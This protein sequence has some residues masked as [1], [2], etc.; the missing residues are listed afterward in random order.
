MVGI[1]TYLALISLNIRIVVHRPYS[2]SNTLVNASGAS[3]DGAPVHGEGITAALRP[4]EESTVTALPLAW[5]IRPLVSFTVYNE[6]CAARIPEDFLPALAGLRQEWAFNAGFVSR[7]TI[8]SCLLADSFL[9][10]SPR[11]V[12][13][14]AIVANRIS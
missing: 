13:F 11:C 6:L 12:S 3:D 10:T 14:S 2:Q 5:Y 9:A 8:V 4:N 1:Q 7:F